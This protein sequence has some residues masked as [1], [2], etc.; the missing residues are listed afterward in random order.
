MIK[1][2]NTAATGMVA[3]QTSIDN[4][5]NNLANVNTTGFKKARIEFQ[6]ILYQN[7][8]KAGTASAIGSMVPVNLD[9]GYGTRAVA[10]SREFSSGSMNITQNPTDL[11]I[12][13]NGFFQVQMP[14]GTIGYTRDGAFKISADGQLVTADGFLMTPEITI[15]EDATDLSVALD[16]IVSVLVVGNDTPQEIGQIEIARFIN[17]AGLSAIGHNLYRESPA[18]GT[19]ITGTPGNEGLGTIDQ[20][21]LEASN[22]AVVDEMVNMIMAQ[23]AYEIN[24][25]V[26]QT[27]DDMSQTINNLKR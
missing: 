26:I 8:R 15:P 2:M 21:Y 24:S 9:V 11:A 6:D 18:S 23:R 3:Q 16:G 1:A 13:G 14:D 7:Y 10:T 5:A 22:V 19:P 12:A 17:P 4:I 25:K 27:S 20:G